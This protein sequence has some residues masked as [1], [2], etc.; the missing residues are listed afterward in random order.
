MPSAEDGQNAQYK[1]IKFMQNYI[2]QFYY[3]VI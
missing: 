3:K 2:L 1:K